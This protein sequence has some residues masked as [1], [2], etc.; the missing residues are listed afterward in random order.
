MKSI[1]HHLMAGVLLMLLSASGIAQ[2]AST[3]IWL[4]GLDPVSRHAKFP[5]MSSDYMDMFQ[6]NAPWNHAA[7]DVNVFEL[8]P[9]FV[10]EASDEML[11]QIFSDL[12]Q[13]NISVAIGHPG[14]LEAMPAARESRASL[15]QE[16]LNPFPIESIG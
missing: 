8:G 11:S 12:K 3:A 13:R 16:P 2:T 7:A 6:P 1:A 5:D 10:M 15:I 4:G 9:K 14:C